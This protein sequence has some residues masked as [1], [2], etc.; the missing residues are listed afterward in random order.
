MFRFVLHLSV[1]I[2]MSIA[3][4]VTVRAQAGWPSWPDR[5]LMYWQ[6]RFAPSEFSKTA[7][8]AGVGEFNQR[9]AAVTKPQGFATEYSVNGYQNLIVDKNTPEIIAITIDESAKHALWA[10]ML[11]AD[12]PKIPWS[13]VHKRYQ[14]IGDHFPESKYGRHATE[15]AETIAKMLRAEKL[16]T[17]SGNLQHLTL[18]QRVDELIFQLMNQDGVQMSQPGGCDFFCND[19]GLTE[20]R[21]SSPAQQ[22]VDIGMPAVPHLVEAL[23]DERFTRS[24]QFHRNFYF[25]HTLLR[26]RDCVISILFRIT[27]EPFYRGKTADDRIRLIEEWWKQHRPNST[28]ASAN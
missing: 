21:K 15:S 11:M 25:S 4:A 7:V 5:D 13:E 20:G 16:R 19:L 24:V 2:C 6:S 18:E 9:A 28:V 1:L 27:K 23:Y 22:L 12:D 3:N 10:V 17:P 26:V 8:V 14:W